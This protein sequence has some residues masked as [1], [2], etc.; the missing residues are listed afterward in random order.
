MRETADGR[1]HPWTADLW[2]Y[3][4]FDDTA[5]VYV[6]YGSDPIFL[7][8]IVV[9]HSL[10]Q[11]ISPNA[12]TA[13]HTLTS[14]AKL[15]SYVM[16]QLNSLHQK[17]KWLKVIKAFACWVSAE[18]NCLVPLPLDLRARTGVQDVSRLC[19]PSV[20]VSPWLFRSYKYVTTFRKV[21]RSLNSNFAMCIVRCTMHR[22]LYVSIV[23]T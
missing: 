13:I 4:I 20:V 2:W 5:C 22:P 17:T 10:S 12:R 3:N 18:L 9:M 21:F 23:C 15:P 14:L 16:S 11:N 6:H 8:G 19:V 1:A 7:V